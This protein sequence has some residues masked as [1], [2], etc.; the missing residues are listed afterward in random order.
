MDRKDFLVSRIAEYSQGYYENGSSDAPDHI[1]DALYDE[2]SNIDPENPILKKI[3]KGYVLGVDDKERYPHPIE[4]G[5][6]PKYKDFLALKA[7][8]LPGA[9]WSAKLD[10]NSIVF[11]YRFGKLDHVVTR[12]EDN[13]GIIR[14]AKFL[15]MKGVKSRIPELTEYEY[16]SIRGEA[17]IRKSKYTEKNGFDISKSSRNA[18]G[19]AIAR[20]DNWEPLFKHLE[21]V[22]YTFTDCINGKDL[23]SLPFWSEHFQVEPQR[24]FCAETVEFLLNHKKTCEFDCDGIVFRNPDGEQFAL[25]FEDEFRETVLTSISNEIG[26]NQRITPVANL[27]PVNLSGATIQRASLGS[28]QLAIDLGLWP[29]KKNSMVRVIRA[30]EII[31]YV[32]QMVSSENEVIQSEIR[33]PVC[34]SVCSQN[35]AHMFCV[36]PECPNIEREF[37]LRFVSFIAPEGLKEKTLNKIFDANSI[38]TIE[39]FLETDL[40]DMSFSVD[41]IGAHAASLY[42]ELKKVSEIPSTVLYQTFFTGCGDRSSS[43]IVKSGFSFSQFIDGDNSQVSKLYS[44]PNFN[45]GIIVEVEKYR[46]RMEDIS[47]LITVFDPHIHVG[48][49]S[50]CATGVRVKGD[51]LEKAKSLGWE[52]KS[53]V[54]EGLNCL[55]VKD[56]ATTSA[57]MTKAKTLKSKPVIVTLEQFEKMLTSE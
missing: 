39:D 34:D 47:D 8:L 25:K 46:E 17:A 52:E 44:I 22:A 24:V 41:G 50:F 49:K 15:K 2:L 36:N 20:K 56:L 33:C 12:G 19:G 51:M 32:T 40:S 30:N 7:K 1:F 28:Y 23:Y 48:T 31:P 57:K 14:T 43:S 53:S 6:I 26:Q 5:S 9:T 3:S 55:I 37:L 35:G 54:S 42:A 38:E 18:V 11:Y 10:G 27:L 16:V 13:I 45:S 4:V 21:F 29:L